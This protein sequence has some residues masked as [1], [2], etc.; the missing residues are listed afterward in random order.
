MRGIVTALSYL[1][2][3]KD[4]IEFRRR[5]ARLNLLRKFLRR[6]KPIVGPPFSRMVDTLYSSVMP[7]LP[8]L[9]TFALVHSIHKIARHCLAPSHVWP[10]RL[11]DICFM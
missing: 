9:I 10:L 11:L 1:A 3:S 4:S 5:V 6:K 8:K 7:I 2:G